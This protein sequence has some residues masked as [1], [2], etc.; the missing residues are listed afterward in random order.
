MHLLLFSASSATWNFFEILLSFDEVACVNS[1]NA[2]KFLLNEIEPQFSVR[3]VCVI[4]LADFVRNIF[5][6]RYFVIPPAFV[7]EPSCSKLQPSR[8]TVPYIFQVYVI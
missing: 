6:G 7:F 8:N 2:L 4:I 5:F 3:Q 1:N